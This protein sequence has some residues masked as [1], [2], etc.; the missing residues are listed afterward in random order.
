MKLKPNRSRPG[1]PSSSGSCER[2]TARVPRWTAFA[3]F[4]GC[5][6]LVAVLGAWRLGAHY[7]PRGRSLPGT[8]IGGRIQPPAVDLE[9]WLVERQTQAQASEVYL[10][11]PDETVESTQG[12]LGCRLDVAETLR[13]VLDY[14]ESGR[15][16]D[17]LARAWQ[18]HRELVDLALSWALDEER[19][20]ATL[21]QLAPR[22]RREPVNARLDLV[23]HKRVPEEPGRELDLERTLDRVRQGCPEARSELVVATRSIP[24]QVTREMLSEVDVSKVL[25][26]YETGFGGTGWGRARN[27]AQAISNLNGI[28]LAPGQVLSFNRAVGPRTVE[29]G[30]TMA[31]VIFDDELTPGLGGGVCQVASTLHAASVLGGM[32]VLERRQHSRPSSYIPMGLD[33]T[34]IF[35]ELDLKIRNP[36]PV[37]VMIHAFLPT[38]SRLRIEILGS[39]PPGKVD[40]SYWVVEKHEFYRRVT[41]KPWLATRSVRQQKGIFGYQVKSLVRWR[42]SDGEVVAHAYQSDYRPTPEVYWIGPDMDPAQLPGLP[43]G[44]TRVEVDVGPA[45]VDPETSA[46]PAGS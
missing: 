17:R 23:G 16:R 39:D 34:V 5:L 12:A 8:S 11:L 13:Q 37:P 45:A 26:S 22:L 6:L 46:D 14:A 43:E 18:A 35:G 20:R 28:V 15:V 10:L 9:T 24:A 41:T 36:Y 4:G 31:P 3:G 29:R 1:A 32:Q 2:Y 40:Y 44:A 19:A 7:L 25:A 38:H 42:R 27:I 30:F 33:A 21:T